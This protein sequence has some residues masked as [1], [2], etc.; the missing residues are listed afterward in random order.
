MRKVTLKDIAKEIGVTTPTVSAALSDTGRVS[1]EMREKVRKAAKAMGYHPNI[2][3]QML[4]S[5]RNNRIGLVINDKP[6]HIYGSGLFE[7]LIVNFIHFCE[8]DDLEYQI[9]I[10]DMQSNSSRLP[11][12]M[13]GGVV[14]GIIYAGYISPQVKEWQRGPSV[15]PM[16]T[17][18][19]QSKYCLINDY[20]E[21]MIQAIQYL[22]ALGHRH[23]RHICGPIKYEIFSKTSQAM[24]EGA[25]QYALNFDPQDDIIE[26][27]TYMKDYKEDAAPVS[28]KYFQNMF[29]EEKVPSA[30]ICSGPQSA[31]AATYAASEAGLKIPSDISIV[32]ISSSWE[33]A[34]SCPSL[35]SI[36]R[37]SE[38]M[39]MRAMSLLQ[40]LMRNT[41][42][43]PSNIYI[44]LKLVTRDSTGKLEL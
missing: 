16:I 44:P 42:V 38:I 13:T 10:C 6:E 32:A 20:R 21:G 1:D 31:R 27:D 39:V 34:G 19:E 41:S 18:D 25:E 43:C 35:T 26:I 33:A 24:I 5:K 7:P 9:E 36:E 17:L 22:A 3:A 28:L 15:L 8:E 12:L 29:K 14:G 4:K 11:R 30:I 2:A 23:I 37:D 40:R